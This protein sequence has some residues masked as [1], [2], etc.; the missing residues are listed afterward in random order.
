MNYET[1]KR[2][3]NRQKFDCGDPQVND[4]LATKAFQHQKKG[5][6]TT[7]VLTSQDSNEV[8]AFYTL[9]PFSIGSGAMPPGSPNYPYNLVPVILIGWLGVDISLQGQ[10][11]GQIV[12]L[13]ALDHALAVMKGFAGVGVVLDAIGPAALDWYLK[14]EIFTQLPGHPNR[15]FVSR[16]TLEKAKSEGK[17]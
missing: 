8:V 16:K 5:V 1:L 6:C 12:L 17:L 4:F 2:A 11:N 3:H 15:L 7:Q 14:Q 10:G 13:E 9:A